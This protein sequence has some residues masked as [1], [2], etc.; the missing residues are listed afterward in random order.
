MLEQTWAENFAADWIEAWNSHDIE[1][2][3]AHYHDD[4]KMTS[5][6]IVQRMNEPSGTLHGKAA[7]Q[8]YWEIGLAAQPPLHFELVEVLVSVNSIAISYRRTSGKSAVEIL[9]FDDARR[10]IQ[11]IAHYGA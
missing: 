6:L 8:P 4:F 1:R 5:P 3:L 2:I 10:V 9:I 11:G 7:I